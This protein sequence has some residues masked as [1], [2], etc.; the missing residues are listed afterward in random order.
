MIE[1]ITI[2]TR[3]HNELINITDRVKE[4]VSQSNIKN[5][6]A[7]IFIPHTT[8]SLA[9]NENEPGLVSDIKKTIRLISTAARISGGFEHDKI[10]HN[11][12]AHIGATLLEPSI[13]LI[14]EAGNLVLGTWQQIFFIEFDGPKTSREIFIKIISD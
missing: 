9:I 6:L 2:A 4:I 11:A 5:G 14:I 7:V 3:D 10:D 13:S 1:K 12:A 8:A